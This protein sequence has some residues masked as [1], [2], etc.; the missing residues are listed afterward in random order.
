MD[1]NIQSK[2]IFLTNSAF[3]KPYSNKERR[4]N[5]KKKKGKYDLKTAFN[6]KY[7]SPPHPFRKSTKNMDDS[8]RLPHYLPHLY[9]FTG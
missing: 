5:R 1:R 9:Y 8:V 4:K 7:A 2:Q 6:I 3:K